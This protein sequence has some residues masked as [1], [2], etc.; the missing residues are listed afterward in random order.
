M[1][2]VPAVPC[3]RHL[4]RRGRAME[5]AQWEEGETPRMLTIYTNHT[6]GNIVHNHKT[7]KFDLVG[8]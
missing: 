3:V 1:N 6:G 2:W 4:D 7:I 5:R 8:E